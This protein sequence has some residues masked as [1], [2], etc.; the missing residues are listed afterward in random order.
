MGRDLREDDFGVLCLKEQL[1]RTIFYSNYLFQTV[2][3]NLVNMWA[4]IVCCVEKHDVRSWCQSIVILL[5]LVQALSCCAGFC[6]SRARSP[7]GLNHR[8]ISWTICKV[9]R[10]LSRLLATALLFTNIHT[11][12]L[13]R[14]LRFSCAG[15]CFGRHF[16]FIKMSVFC[17]TQFCK[18]V[19]LLSKVLLNTPF[20]ISLPWCQPSWCCPPMLLKIAM[21]SDPA[22]HTGAQPSL[23]VCNCRFLF[24]VWEPLGFVCACKSRWR[25]WGNMTCSF[26]TAVCKGFSLWQGVAIGKGMTAGT[27]TQDM[28]APETWHRLLLLW[29]VVAKQRERAPGE[30]QNNNPSISHTHRR[31]R[32]RLVGCSVR[33]DFCCESS[34]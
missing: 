12:V 25:G 13:S 3:S 19:S 31:E 34:N 9:L 10:A 7:K 8:I 23:F 21:G 29:Q 16:F 32:Y 20:L 27:S 17:M 14:D 28:G 24:L 30:F 11:I 22:L 15:G 18:T 4:E 6:L 1:H 26:Q 5:C 2:S 33:W